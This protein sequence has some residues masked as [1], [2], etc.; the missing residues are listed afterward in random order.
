LHAISTTLYQFSASLTEL[1][2]DGTRLLFEGPQIEPASLAPTISAWLLDYPIAYLS[3]SNAGDTCLGGIPLTL[4]QILGRTVQ[5]EAFRQLYSF[6][7]P[8]SVGGTEEDEMMLKRAVEEWE[9]ALMAP[10]S[11]TMELNVSRSDVSRDRILL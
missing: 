7:F 2:A 9:R 5:T 10:E 4:V 3:D 1:L 11:S 8:D 6:T